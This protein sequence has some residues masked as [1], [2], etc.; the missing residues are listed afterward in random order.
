MAQVQLQVL[1]CKFVIITFSVGFQYFETYLETFAKSLKK[2]SRV[3]QQ[4]ICHTDLGPGVGG[5]LGA[6]PLKR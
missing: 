6:N 5:C 2:L 3:H 1:P 4:K